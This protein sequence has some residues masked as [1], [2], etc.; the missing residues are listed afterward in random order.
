M[1]DV[2]A[3]AK[4]EVNSHQH[5]NFRGIDAVVNAVGPVLRKHRVIVVPTMRDIYR[6]AVTVGA[7]Q[8]PMQAVSLTVA[9]RFYGPAGDYLEAVVAGESMDSGD[10]ATAKAMSV[11]FRTALLQTLALPTTDPD[12]DLDTYETVTPAVQTDPDVLKDALDGLAQAT[13][14]DELATV[15]GFIKGAKDAGKL[16]PADLDNLH[17]RYTQKQNELGA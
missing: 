15:A 2:R 1:A 17:R 4:S 12:P 16:S 10:K 13:T 6:Q 8:T 3:V 7:K 11:A 14:T 5:F 9:Y